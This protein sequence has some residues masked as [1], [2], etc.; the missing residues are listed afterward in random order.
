MLHTEFLF[1]FLICPLIK[2]LLG[3]KVHYV[4]FETTVFWVVISC[5]SETA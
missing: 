1:T 4:G 5:S 3:T 2:Y